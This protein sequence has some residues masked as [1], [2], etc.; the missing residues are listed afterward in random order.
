MTIAER[1]SI[2]PFLKLCFVYFWA[3]S[4]YYLYHFYPILY[5][6]QY[7]FEEIILF[8]CYKLNFM[9]P[10]FPQRSFLIQYHY[11]KLLT[12]NNQLKLCFN[13]DNYVHLREDQQIRRTN[14]H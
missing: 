7:S 8:S 11:L 12:N 5:K 1:L 13:E 14:E 2:K 3:L 6:S 4:S 10:I 9:D